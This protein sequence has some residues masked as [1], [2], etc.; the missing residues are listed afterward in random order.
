MEEATPPSWVVIDRDGNAFVAVDYLDLIPTSSPDK[1]IRDR[2]FT[3]PIDA[4]VPG[5]AS[6]CQDSHLFVSLNHLNNLLASA[7]TRPLHAS[8]IASVTGE[9]YLWVSLRLEDSL[10]EAVAFDEPACD[11]LEDLRELAREGDEPSGDAT[12]EAFEDDHQLRHDTPQENNDPQDK[13]TR[14]GGLSDLGNPQKHQKAPATPIPTMTDTI[15]TPPR[16]GPQTGGDAIEATPFVPTSEKDGY[17]CSSSSFCSDL[18]SDRQHVG[19]GGE[20]SY[21]HQFLKQLH[22]LQLTDSTTLATLLRNRLPR[23]LRC[24]HGAHD[25]LI[26]LATLTNGKAYFVRIFR[27]LHARREDLSFPSLADPALAD[28]SITEYKKIELLKV[29]RCVSDLSGTGSQEHDHSSA[30]D[31]S[32]MSRKLFDRSYRTTTQVYRDLDRLTT[33]TT[34]AAAAASIKDIMRKRCAI[35]ASDILDPLFHGLLREVVIH[36]GEKQR[37]QQQQQDPMLPVF[38]LPLGRLYEVDPS[39]SAQPRP[40]ECFVLL[41]VATPRKA[42]WLFRRNKLINDLVLLAPDVRQ[43]RLSSRRDGGG[44]DFGGLLA[45]SGSLGSGGGD[46]ILARR[47]RLAQEDPAF[48]GEEGTRV[49]FRRVDRRRA[50]K[51]IGRGWGGSSSSSSLDSPLQTALLNSVKAARAPPATPTKQ[52]RKKRPREETEEQS[53]RRER[54]TEAGGD[55][56]DDEWTPASERQRKARRPRRVWRRIDMR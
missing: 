39:P 10:G 53:A 20:L 44:N 13:Q 42:L 36:P 37:Q 38:V 48:V 4:N 29:L 9:G 3:E 43:W 31:L 45:G 34:G 30:A 47:S 15:N 11:T 27:D 18:E 21:Q 28:Q 7:P 26:H 52:S 25:E 17:S 40:L 23:A 55:G 12:Q 5:P 51:V 22:K 46:E 50:A 2:L 14:R 54:P 33:T 41:D 32:P 8:I 56:S 35:G 1:P 49:H 16:Q 24:L 6:I 19:A